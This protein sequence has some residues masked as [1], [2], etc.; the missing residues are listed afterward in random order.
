MCDWVLAPDLRTLLN[1]EIHE[2][3]ELKQFQFI[4]RHSHNVRVGVHGSRKLLEE[5]SSG[6]SKRRDG[7]GER[8]EGS[9][10]GLHI[11]ERE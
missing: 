3:L 5:R 1:D 6:S 7:D 10:E 2:Y 9:S 11:C 4:K 8:S